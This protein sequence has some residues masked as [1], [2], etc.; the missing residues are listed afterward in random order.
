V[1]LAEF[2]GAGPEGRRTP[3][4][5][6]W[7]IDEEGAGQLAAGMGHPVSAGL[8]YAGKAGGHRSSA[9]PSSSTLWSR[10]A[11]NHLRGNIGSSTFRRSLAAL[12]TPAGVAVA[13]DSLTA[14]MHAHLKVAVLPVPSEL[15]AELEGELVARADPPLNLAGAAQQPARSALSRLRTLLSR[16]GGSSSPEEEAHVDVP[17]QAS[18]SAVA[19]S[20]F[21]H[22]VRV[23]LRAV[24][25]AGYRPTIFQ[26]MLAE[27]GAVGT[28]QRLLAASTLS[29]GFR[30]LWEHGLLRHSI[31][32]A[33]LAD[34]FAE[35]FTDKEKTVARMRLADA[36]YL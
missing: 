22:R 21:D 29:D 24:I 25:A 7:W 11:G 18:S 12:L 33:V 36:G 15:V 35:L 23:D 8:L 31:E 34:D 5:Y 26:R 9:E 17:M 14:W 32:N 20:A 19:A 16:T 13:E 4:L 28:A 2:L 3:G 30:Y 1:T 27:S 6:A 10:V